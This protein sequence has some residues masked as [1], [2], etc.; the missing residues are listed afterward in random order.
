MGLL[1]VE[2]FLIGSG[3]RMSQVVIGDLAR[4]SKAA[5]VIARI[6]ANDADGAFEGEFLTWKIRA[7][8]GDAEFTGED[9]TGNKGNPG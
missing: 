9:R 5:V 7:K 1:V 4:N 2:A 6:D 8:R 3:N